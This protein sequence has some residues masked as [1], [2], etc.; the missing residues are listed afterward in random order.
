[1]LELNISNQLWS[2]S[3]GLKPRTDRSTVAQHVH[4]TASSFFPREMRLL[5]H[6][7]SH[8]NSVFQLSYSH[9]FVIIYRTD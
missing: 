9:E 5:Y 3:E 4:C 6:Q 7:S 1:L 8:R 2:T